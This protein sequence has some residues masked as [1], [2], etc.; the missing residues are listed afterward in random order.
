MCVFLMNV[1]ETVD[2][3]Q[4]EHTFTQKVTITMSDQYCMCNGKWCYIRGRQWLWKQNKGFKAA[5]Y[6]YKL[7]KAPIINIAYYYDNTVHSFAY[8]VIWLE[9]I[10]MTDWD[11]EREDK[12]A[13]YWQIMESQ[14]CMWS[15]HHY[16]YRTLCPLFGTPIIHCLCSPSCGSQLHWVHTDFALVC[17]TLMFLLFCIP[18][19]TEKF[20]I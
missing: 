10:K 11:K 15:T 13:L 1:N 16:H 2:A 12:A 7:F 18:E 17:Q 5:Q 3:D 9:N 20:V 4:S 19:N 14:V 8:L 6:I